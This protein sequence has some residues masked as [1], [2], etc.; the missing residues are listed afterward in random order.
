[1]VQSP[2]QPV[3][4][5]GAES[6]TTSSLVWCRVLYSQFS[7]MVQ[8]PV[9]PVSSL[10]WCRVLY[11]QFS[12][13][14]TQKLKTSCYR[15]L[16]NIRRIDRVTNQHVFNVTQREQISK[17]LLSKQL[18]VL[19]HLLRRPNETTIMKYALYTKN[20]GK[21]RRGRPCAI[22]VKLMEKVKGM[23]NHALTKLCKNRKECRRFVVWR[24]DTQ[25]PG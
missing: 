2:V 18:R 7:C 12:C 23:D 22:Y 9:Q 16:L 10:A 14:A 1:M 11:S 19:G 21:N 5:Y 4:L 25:T 17:I 15:I 8:S 20:Q 13:T 3:L 24:I 6:C